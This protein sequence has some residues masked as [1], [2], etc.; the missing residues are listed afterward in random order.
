MLWQQRFSS[1]SKALTCGSC[2]LLFEGLPGNVVVAEQCWRHVL[3]AGTLTCGTCHLFR[4][5][6]LGRGGRVR[7]DCAC[8]SDTS[9]V[10]T[11]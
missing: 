4:I 1:C 3:S 5:L 9:C 7:T 8:L 11:F 2:V 6:E 10:G